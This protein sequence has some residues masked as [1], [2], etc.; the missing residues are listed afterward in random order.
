MSGLAGTK[1]A[2]FFAL[3]QGTRFDNQD[4]NTSRFQLRALLARRQHLIEE[5]HGRLARRIH[6]EISQKLTLLA[7]QLSL[8]ASGQGLARHRSSTADFLSDGRRHSNGARTDGVSAR[9]CFSPTA[10]FPEKCKSWGTMVVEIGQA[11][12]EITD[13]LQPKVVEEFGLVAGL[14]WY[15]NSLNEEVRCTFTPP[16]RDVVLA[17]GMGRELFGVCWEVI[18]SIFRPETTSHVDIQVRQTDGTLT[19]HLHGNDKQGA[20]SGDPERELDVISISERLL[21]LGGTVEVNCA[22]GCG[23][24][25]ILCLPPR[26]LR[27]VDLPPVGPK[28]YA[29]GSGR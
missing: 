16:E 17:P 27:R 3:R 14:Q 7:L 8:E 26:T 21:R 25:V 19:I 4:M 18:T 20:P 9:A 23:T 5:Q 22:P 13:I 12:R 10:T 6:D 11:L 29:H 15:A 1:E 2:R 24:A 28:I